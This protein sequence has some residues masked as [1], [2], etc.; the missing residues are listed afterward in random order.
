MC[1]IFVGSYAMA[2]KQV[3]S[4]KYLARPYFEQNFACCRACYTVFHMFGHTVVVAGVVVIA[5]RAFPN[6]TSIYFPA[7]PRLFWAWQK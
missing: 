6:T 1:F 7:S 3:Q 4:S 5:E 2:H